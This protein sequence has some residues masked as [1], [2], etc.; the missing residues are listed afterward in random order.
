MNPHRLT[1]LFGCLWLLWSAPLRADGP[2]DNDPAKVRQVPPPGIDVGDADRQ[3]LQLGLDALGAALDGMRAQ[4][5]HPL[6]ELLPDVEIFHRAVDQALRYGEMFHERDVRSADNLL[7]E[8][9]ARAK[10]LSAGEAPWT[11]QAGLVV[12]GFRSRLD[13]TVQPYGLVIPASY[14]FDGVRRHRCDLWFHGRGETSVELQFIQQRMTQTGQ[15]APEDAIVLHPFGRYSNAFKFAGEVDVFEALEHARRHYRIDSRRTAVRGFSMGGAGCWHFA[16]HHPDQWFAAT[17]GAGFSETPEFLK[18]FQ[19]ETLNPPWWEEKLWLWYDCPP[20]VANLLHCPTIAYSGEIDRQK[21]AADVMVD[22]FRKDTINELELVHVIG[23]ETA[24]KI[25]P[26]SLVEIESRLSAIDTIS[27][28]PLP[29]RVR[30]HTYTLGY[31]GAHWLRINGL[32]RH[33]ERAEV[34]AR[35]DEYGRI[36]IYHTNVSDVTI[37]FPPGSLGDDSPLGDVI[38]PL[39]VAFHTPR[40]DQSEWPPIEPVDDLRLR[41]KSDGSFECRFVKENNQWRLFEPQDDEGL[42]KR[43]GLQGPIDDALMNSFLFVTPSSLSRH[44]QVE[45]WVQSE[46]KRATAHW[47]QQMRGDVRMK[48]DTEITEE[49]IAAH[50]LI[51]WGDPRSNAVLAKILPHLPLEWTDTAILIGQQNFDSSRTVPALIY[52]NPLNPTKYVVLNSSLTYR[53]YD[54]LNNAR[55]TPKLP[56]WAVFD[57]SEPPGARWAGKV[58]AADFFDEH[59]EVRLPV[60]SVDGD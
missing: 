58:V 19:G 45:N 4:A 42:H 57:L 60:P 25:H 3:R 47:R 48:S 30:F 38:S 31:N 23:P 1:V 43:P 5:E 14:D 44:D 20:W 39:Q 6:A 22:A 11:R 8:G 46:L 13:G 40:P 55:Q 17:P 9:L 16:V 18:S 50:N 51:L 59:W 2:A 26:D 21:Q 10:S 28:I 49:D 7:A 27:R 41:V 12:R 53:E 15:I 24:H 56:D 54:Y 52:P 32:D 33:W 29:R 36:T 35:M 37:S 34:D